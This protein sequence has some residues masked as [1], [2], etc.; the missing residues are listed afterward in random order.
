MSSCHVAPSTRRSSPILSTFRS[1]SRRSVHGA[2]LRPA[3]A[4]TLIGRPSERGVG[5]LRKV[6]ASAALPLPRRAGR[7]Y[8]DAGAHRI[9]Q[10]TGTREGESAMSTGAP[11]LA[12]EDRLP[13]EWRRSAYDR[14][15]EAEGIPVVQDIA[16]SDL[17]RVEVAS[18]RRVEARGAYIRLAGTEDTNSAYVLEIPPGGRT[19]AQRHL[20]EEFYFVVDG[21]G[22]CEVWNQAGVRRTFEWQAGSLFSIPLNCFHR[23][24]SGSG[25]EPA[26][27]LGVT[28]AS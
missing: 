15:L 17:R 11:R 28:T 3:L 7:C 27:L 20:Y 1:Q 22:A 19:A 6:H 23:L 24:Y 21:R 14:W 25:R 2:V 5:L 16:V 18:W 13:P 12:Q 4:V 26:R 10:T 8:I 9:V